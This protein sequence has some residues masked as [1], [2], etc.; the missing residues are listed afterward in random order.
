MF[1]GVPRMRS[2]QIQIYLWTKCGYCKQQEA[3]IAKLSVADRQQLRIIRVD[4]PVKAGPVTSF[5]TTID[6]KGV[7][8]VGVRKATELRAMIRS[9]HK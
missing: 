6:G 8:H 4:Q 3:E 7:P 9:A 2:G 1:A 5:P